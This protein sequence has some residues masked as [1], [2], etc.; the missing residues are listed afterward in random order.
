MKRRAISAIRLLEMLPESELSLIEKESKVDFQVKKL[1][2]RLIFKLL[3]YG[4]LSGKELSWRIL[5][6]LIHSNR[7]GKL[8]GLSDDFT[9]DH[10]SLAERVSNIQV[11]YFEKLFKRT[12]EIM[13][14]HCPAE[15]VCTYKLIRCDSTFVNIA[16]TLLKMGGM[17][18]GVNTRKKKEVHPVAVK[19]SVG[20]D[21]MQL[22]DVKM[23][24]TDEYMS[25]DICLPELISEGIWEDKEVAVFDR[26][27]QSRDAF[28]KFSEKQ[29]KFVTRLRRSARG[30]IKHKKVRD[31]T[32][33]EEENPI[34]TQTLYIEQDIEVFLYGKTGRKTKN[35]YRLIIAKMKSNNKPI[36]FLS[37]ILDEVDTASITEI[38][39]RRWDIE[40]FFKHIKQE[41]GFKHFL[42][43]NENGIQVM[44][45]MTLIAAMLIFVYQHVNKIEGFKI[46]KLWFINELDEEIMR[47]VVQM[48]RGNPDLIGRFSVF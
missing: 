7:F 2:G 39:K 9:T 16:S 24:H 27:L 4:L 20:F 21:G 6:V 17:S 36:A 28:D 43:R 13:S 31:I 45:Y 10:S 48:C 3:L 15:R 12:C 22:K 33:I 42:S 18:A 30:N 47:I 46:A 25:D 37:N 29:I 34:E 26:G 38:Y 8:A 40:V 23:F 14:E 32:I 5:E 1:S 35:T 41:F 19:F 44:L 11:S